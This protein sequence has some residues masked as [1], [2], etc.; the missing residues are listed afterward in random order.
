MN[1]ALLLKE[2]QALYMSFIGKRRALFRESGIVVARNSMCSHSHMEMETLADG[3]FAPCEAKE[4][5][6]A[7][8]TITAYKYIRLRERLERMVADR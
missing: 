3:S 2:K 6:G 1:D 8:A 5:I 4:C 7:P